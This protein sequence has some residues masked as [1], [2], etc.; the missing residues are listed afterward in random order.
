MEEILVVA[1]R[2]VVRTGVRATALLA[3]DAGHDHAERGVEHVPELD[4]LREIAVEDVALTAP[5]AEPEVPAT[6]VRM[7]WM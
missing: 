6:T 1:R 3:R 4:R 5:V 2:V 7:R